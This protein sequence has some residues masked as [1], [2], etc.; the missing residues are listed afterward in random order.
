MVTK[1]DGQILATKFGFVPDW[2]C[3]PSYLGLN[4]SICHNFQ[5]T[6]GQIVFI[7]LSM[8]LCERSTA[9]SICSLNALFR[10]ENFPTQILS[11]MTFKHEKGWKLAGPSGK[12]DGQAHFLLAEGIRLAINVKTV[13]SWPSQ[14]CQRFEFFPAASAQLCTEI[15]CFNLTENMIKNIP[16]LA[17]ALGD[18]D[19]PPPTSAPPASDAS[20]GPNIT[21]QGQTQVRASLTHWRPPWPSRSNLTWKVKISLCPVSSPE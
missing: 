4:V 13:H 21:E 12:L 1:F 15:W 7:L 3:R 10:F 11:L 5:I 2:K 18:F 20:S 14:I 16:L 8:S 6:V 9:N 19:R 17:G